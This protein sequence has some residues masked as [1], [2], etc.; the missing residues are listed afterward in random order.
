MKRFAACAPAWLVLCLLVI[1]WPRKAWAEEDFEQGVDTVRQLLESQRY[2]EALSRIVELK[3]RAQG[4]EQKLELS[5]YEGLV[6]ASMG[7]RTQDRASAAFRSALQVDPRVRLPVKVPP[8]LE[9]TFEELRARVLKEQAERPAPALEVTPAPLAT[10]PTQTGTSV[11]GE[12]DM[13]DRLRLLSQWPSLAAPAP[14]ATVPVTA[15]FQ[16]K[17]SRPR[18]LVP[19]LTGGALAVSGGVLWGLARREQSRLRKLDLGER[20]LEDAQL[21]AVRGDRYQNWALGTATAGGVALG[22]ATVL[23]VLQVPKPPVTL[24]T[25]GSSAFLQGEW[26]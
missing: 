17:A 21:L 20:T 10:E 9:R 2:D 5:L 25:S 7:R 4:P 1:G 22:V 24:G 16:Y 19:A 6:L 8:R 18:V 26:P 11:P 15:T 13:S 12:L 3:P 23:Y 14:P